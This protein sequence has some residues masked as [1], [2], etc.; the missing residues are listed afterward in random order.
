MTPHR[1]VP[2]LA[3]L[4]LLAGACSPSSAPTSQPGAPTA[5]NPGSSNVAPSTKTLVAAV[6]VEPATVATRPLRQTGVALY[7]P[8][9]MFNAGIAYLDGKGVPH[10]YLVEALPELGTDSWK[11]LDDGHM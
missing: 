6:R 5:G 11:L 3:L 10:P 9:G 8:T 7:L 4:V 1:L 2:V